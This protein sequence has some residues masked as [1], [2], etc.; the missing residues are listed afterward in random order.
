VPERSGPPTSSPTSATTA[1]AAFKISTG[2]EGMA[3]EAVKANLSAGEL[4][5]NSNVMKKM[6]ATPFRYSSSLAD[7]TTTSAAVVAVVAV[8]AVVAV[9]A[10][11]AAT[12]SDPGVVE[13]LSGGGSDMAEVIELATSSDLVALRGRK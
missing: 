10:V 8:A 12:A 13:A 2:G 4:E 1:T 11:V 5:A 6:V 9:V 7:G 3:V